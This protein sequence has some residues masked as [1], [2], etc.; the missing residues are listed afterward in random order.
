[1]P[2]RIASLGRRMVTASPA[3]ADGAGR[4]PLR[5]E[6]GEEQVALP[7]A[8][9]PADAED[10]APAQVERHPARAGR[11]RRSSTRSALSPTGDRW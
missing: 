1:M 6:Q 2:A 3:D 9:E 7:L 10:L 11:R 5:A 8:G 4:G